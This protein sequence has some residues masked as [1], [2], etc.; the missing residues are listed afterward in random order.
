M[1]G[2][3]KLWTS[4]HGKPVAQL[5]G[6]VGWEDEYR[7]WYRAFSNWVHSDPS[8]VRGPLSYDGRAIL[9]Y[10]HHYFARILLRIAD[11]GKMILTAEQ[12]KTLKEFARNFT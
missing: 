9:V 8:Q 5:A 12:Y 6:L 10:T 4:W 2:N 7:L 1:S 11:H 3:K